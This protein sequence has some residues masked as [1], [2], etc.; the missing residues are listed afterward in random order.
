MDSDW[1]P[2]PLLNTTDLSRPATSVMF[3][4]YIGTVGKVAEKLNADCQ[5]FTPMF[6]ESETQTLNSTPVMCDAAIQTEVYDPHIALKY[7]HVAA[8]GDEQIRVY[9]GIPCIQAFLDIFASLPKINVRK[10]CTKNILRPIDQ[11]LLVLMRLKLG[12]VLSDLSFRFKIAETTCS[13]LVNKWI[14]HLHTHLSSLIYWP[15]RAQINNTMPP[16]FKG[17]FQRT[18]VVID[19]TELSA[20]TPKSLA[21]QSLMYSNYK[22]RMTWKGLVGITPNGVVSFVSDLWTGSIS[23]KQ[24]V[25]ESGLLGK[26]QRGDAIMADKGFLISDLTTPLGIDLII[27]PRKK[28]NK[29]FTRKETVL[30][31]K[32]ANSRI[33]VERHMA[34]VKNFR[35]LSHL[36]GSMKGTASH[37]WR[38]CNALTALQ[39]PLHP[40]D[41]N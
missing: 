19:C 34:R 20:D 36:S 17:K 6:C 41:D 25:I 4:D 32:V 12:L 33:H 18:R 39:D 29:Q 23:D 10:G 27:P 1:E 31:R 21:E 28:S 3:H 14:E 26:C 9:T 5:T 7:E 38:L 40:H 8:Q 24:I 15:T 11:F 22:S 2:G 30:T 37:I 35:I 16:D 13:T